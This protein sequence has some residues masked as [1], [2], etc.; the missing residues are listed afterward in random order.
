MIRINRSDVKEPAVLTAEDDLKERGGKRSAA[1][2]MRRAAKS[3]AAWRAK[4]EAERLKKPWSFDFAIY[5]HDDVKRAL[6]ELF[7]GKC[8]YCES[9]YAATQPMDV[10]HW[11]PKGSVEGESDIG[12]W[13]TAASWEN[14]LPSCIDCNRRRTQTDH[15]EGT[16]GPS[17]KQA[18][19]PIQAGSQRATDVG[20]L[21]LEVPLLLDPCTDDPESILE[22]NM[23]EAS[24]APEGESN[25]LQRSKATESI[26]VY[27]LNRAALVFERKERLL[28][29][30]H[31]ID[32]IEQLAKVLATASFQDADDARP[33]VILEGMIQEHILAV[34]QMAKANQPYAAMIRQLIKAHRKIFKP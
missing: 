21:V 8:A 17:G 32:V 31:R 2:E 14:L 16:T 30:I 27:G 34:R 29:A 12:Y 22:F 6:T 19:F 25:S 9:R 15:V 4:P 11:R 20:E 13:F 18:E 1:K 28:Q 3:L 26:R 5:K 33:R 7:H 10:E 23:D 24:V